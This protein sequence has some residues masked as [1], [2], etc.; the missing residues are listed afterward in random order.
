MILYIASGNS[1]ELPTNKYS[2][3]ELVT[4]KY[5]TDLIQVRACEYEQSRAP[6]S[7]RMRVRARREHY[8]ACD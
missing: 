7:M 6:S 1:L 5:G 3:M 2:T 8:H 4:K